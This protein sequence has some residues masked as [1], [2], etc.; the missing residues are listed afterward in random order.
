MV[1]F[2][3]NISVD[4]PEKE[5]VSRGAHKLIRALDHFDIDPSGLTCIDVGLQQ[6]DLPMC[7]FSERQKSFR[8]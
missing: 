1:P 6:V 3:S 7:C 5:W 8:C 2:D 4:A